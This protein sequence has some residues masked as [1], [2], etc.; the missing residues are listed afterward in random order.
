MELINSYLNYWAKKYIKKK[1]AE[2]IIVCGK[3]NNDLISFQV[4]NLLKNRKLLSIKASKKGNLA[5]KILNVK[6]ITNLV[7]FLAAPFE[8]SKDFDILVVN[9]PS[10]LCEELCEIVKPAI[11]IFTDSKSGKKNEEN[12]IYLLRRMLKS[13]IAIFNSD[14]DLIRKLSYGGRWQRKTFGVHKDSMIKKSLK[15]GGAVYALGIIYN[16]TAQEIEKAI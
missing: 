4:S 16:L 3:K 10:G 7:E 9:M 8:K 13:G 5:K 6:K 14:D 11:I 2:V 15:N 1:R 12:I